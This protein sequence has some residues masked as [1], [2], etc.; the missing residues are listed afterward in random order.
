MSIL[1]KDNE[2]DPESSGRDRQDLEGSNRRIPRT[3][4]YIIASVVR[5]GLLPQNNRVVAAVKGLYKNSDIP[6]DPYLPR[7]GP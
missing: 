7:C 5:L 2:V 1:S 6:P 3:W 4:K